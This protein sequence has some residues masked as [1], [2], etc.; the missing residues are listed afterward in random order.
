VAALLLSLALPA[1]SE[2]WP[3]YRH[4]NRRSAVTAEELA[5]PLKPERVWVHEAAQP[6]RA[7]TRESPAQQDFWHSRYTL[8]PKMT[9]DRA[10]HPVIVGDSVFVGSFANDKVYCLD[11]ATGQVR[12]SFFTEGPVRMAPAVEGGRVFVGS[13]DGR[14][15]CLEASDGSL[16]WSRLVANDGRRLMG[17]GRMISRQPLRAGVLVQDG[18]VYYCA[19]MLPDEGVWMGAVDAATGAD[20]AAGA[21]RRSASFHPQGYL[22]ADADRLYAPNS[23]S[24]PR[25]F[26]LS[27]GAQVG[28]FGGQGGTFA[29]LADDRF[30]YG[31]NLEGTLDEY[32]RTTGSRIATYSGLQMVVSGSRAYVADEGSIAAVTRPGGAIAWR[33]TEPHPFSIALAGDLLLAGGDGR[34]SAWRAADGDP[35]WSAEV[36]GRVYG[37]AIANHRL[38]ASTDEGAV[39]CFADATVD[40]SAVADWIHF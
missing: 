16:L 2:D 29:L 34:V 25:V 39:W 20:A 14:I 15:Y 6:P 37:L 40:V 21:W 13:D 26:R 8:Q 32:P 23:R 38:Y 22:L 28:S 5:L 31:P 24:A 36:P 30:I 9:H 35:V 27:D 12:W 17:D 11:Q 18:L 7:A 1:R 3:V 19:G 33:R 10:F 4:D